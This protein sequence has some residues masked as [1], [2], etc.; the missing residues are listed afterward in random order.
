MDDMVAR[1]VAQELEKIERF[2]RLLASAEWRRN[3][4]LRE[5]ERRRSSFA[6]KLRREIPKFEA[7]EI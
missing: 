6:E 1:A 3:T 2:N 5:I 7:T 4:V